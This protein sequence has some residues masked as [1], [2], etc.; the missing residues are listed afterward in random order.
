MM[1]RADW[2]RR[3]DRR[4]RAPAWPR[5]RAISLLR[6]PIRCPTTLTKPLIWK[7]RRDA[8]HRRWSHDQ[9]DQQHLPAASRTFISP[10]LGTFQEF[11]FNNWSPDFPSILKKFAFRAVINWNVT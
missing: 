6:R 1:P 3:D 7:R 11:L 8:Q 5:S 4:S 10:V 2:R 9:L